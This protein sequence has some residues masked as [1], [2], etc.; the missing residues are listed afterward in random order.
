MTRGKGWKIFDVT[1]LVE[2]H[3]KSASPLYGVLLRF[4][5][6]DRK[7]DDTAW[8]GYQF[9]SR[10]GIGEWES[11]RP[12][13]LVVD[14]DQPP[15][16]EHKE[17]AAKVARAIDLSSAELLEYIE[18]LASLPDVAVRPV[19]GD[20]DALFA[21]R[22]EA[23]DALTKNFVGNLDPQTATSKMHA[24]QLPAYER[25]VAAYPLTPEG[26]MTMSSIVAWFYA[27]L[28]RGHDA[29]RLAAA[30][31]RLAADTEIAC[32]VE[33]NRA[34]IES[35]VDKHQAA[36]ARLRR[37]MEQTP[38]K[39]EDRRTADILLV[40]PLKLADLL[41]EWGQPEKADQLY[42]EVA[43]RGM[44]W[45]RKHPDPNHIGASYVKPAYEGR[46]ELVMRQNPPNVA[47]AEKLI[48]EAKKRLPSIVDELQGDLSTLKSQAPPIGRAQKLAPGEG[49][50]DRQRQ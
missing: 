31:T 27:Q 29:E 50:H 11:L 26:V 44:E 6:E 41:R 5:S 17:P 48:E 9:V 43:D 22:K 13:L 16:A 36:E 40:A 15:L 49:N 8:S 37:V 1:P 10:E 38:P 25:F 46:I 35:I 7:T 45:D 39:A 14:P 42:R 20:V 23:D 21:A 12:V 33:I 2:Q 30:T 34:A 24:A 19:A 28:D 47:A 4:S 18:Y 3:L 32:I